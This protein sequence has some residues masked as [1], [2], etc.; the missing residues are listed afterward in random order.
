MIIVRYLTRETLKSQFAVLFVLFLVFI[1]QKFIRILA[2]ATEGSIPSDLILTLMGLY[3]PS[4]AL[5]MLPLSL[6]IGILLTFGRLYAESE[7]TV[8]NATGIG[9][10]FLIQAALWLAIITGSI[11]A[12]NALWLSPWSAEQETRVMEQVEADSGLELLVKGQF[13]AAP[14]GKGVVFVNDI[15]DSGSRLHKVFVAQLSAQDALRP[16]V[17]VADRG[18][19]S[20]LPDGR[21]IL[22]LKEGTRYE[23]LP[24]R[25]DY[26]ITEFDGYQALIGQRAVRE[27]DRDWDALPTLEL[28][29]RPELAAKAEFQWRM[30]LVI[31]IP[32]LTM[33]VVPLSSVN[34]RQGRFA[35][36]VPAVLIYL[37]YFLAISAAK[38]AVEDGGLPS[39]IGLWSINAAMLLVAIVLNSW[40]TLPVRQLRE[41]FRRRG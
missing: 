37:A 25:L 29:Q 8:M 17:L 22:E 36:L 2:S 28:M 41:K 23:G 6:Y 15:T 12:F 21:Q 34:P 3:M 30:S 26:S 13:Q 16:S 9:N 10:K 4:M 5:L 39:Y 31:C 35:K 20:E 19:V 18:Y 7:I 11:A 38:S 32:L 14:D 24:T 1:S 27:K 33:V 40:D